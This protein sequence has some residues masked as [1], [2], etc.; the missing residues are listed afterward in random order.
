MVSER[1]T[2]FAR[3]ALE[4]SRSAIKCARRMSGTATSYTHVARLQH[5][6]G[7]T[8]AVDNLTPSF[9]PALHAPK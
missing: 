3:C 9:L 4:C 6:S 7:K 5:I 8:V 2:D 1:H